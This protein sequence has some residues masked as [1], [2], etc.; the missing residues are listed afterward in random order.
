MKL[1][2]VCIGSQSEDETRQLYCVAF[3]VE[4]DSPLAH[5]S[6]RDSGIRE[7]LGGFLLGLQRGKLPIIRPDINMPLRPDDFIW[8]LGSRQMAT[9][10]TRRGLLDAEGYAPA[11]ETNA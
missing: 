6:I 4:R 1:R 3:R 10:L 2:S 5:S 8:V 9:L 11:A 7:Q